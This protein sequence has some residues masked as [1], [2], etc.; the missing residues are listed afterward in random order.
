MRKFGLHETDQRFGG[1]EVLGLAGVHFGDPLAA[2]LQS[3]RFQ[4]AKVFIPIEDDVIQQRNSHDRSRSLE[5]RRD[6]DIAGRWLDPAG[7][8][9]VSHNDPSPA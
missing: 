9:I 5:L 4:K 7:W 2:N 8:M 1:G 6:I 3:P